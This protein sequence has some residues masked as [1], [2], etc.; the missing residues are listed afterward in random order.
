ME[1]PQPGDTNLYLDAR[2]RP[3][4]YFITSGLPNLSN[5]SRT[6]SV[7]FLQHALTLLGYPL[8]ADGIFGAR[9]EQAVRAFQR[10]LLLTEDG[11]VSQMEWESLFN[12]ICLAG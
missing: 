7:F 12:M 9:T 1:R 11:I 8:T 3:S 5:G 6:N 10:R 2:Y 4:D